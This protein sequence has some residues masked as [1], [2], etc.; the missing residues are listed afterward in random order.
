M[1][2]AGAVARFAIRLPLRQPNPYQAAGVKRAD[3]CIVIAADLIS[4]ACRRLSTEALARHI[5]GPGAVAMAACRPAV[6][7]SVFERVSFL[8][9]EPRQHQTTWR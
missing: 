6:G 2:L 8:E 7:R 3:G 9:F 4:V 1:M 5:A